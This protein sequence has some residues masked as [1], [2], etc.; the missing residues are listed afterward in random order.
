MTEE[1]ASG[2]EAAPQRI[3][4]VVESTSD[5]FTAQCYHLYRSPPLGAF[6][7]TDAPSNTASSAGQE[8]ESSHIYAVVCGVSTQALDPGRHV[9]ARGEDAD[10]EDEIYRSNP[11]LARLLC[12]RLE[13][14][15]VG[16]SDGGSAFNQYL[17]ALPPRIHAFVYPCIFEEVAHF[18]RSLDYLYLL[19]HSSR[20]GRGVADEVVAAC[21][22]QASAQLDDP[23]SFLVRA[24]KAL[25]V[26]L[27]DDLPRLNSI[28]RRLS[29]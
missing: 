16:H 29:P 4:E 5:R 14:L 8:G 3:G 18:T 27:T 28:L 11:Q 21:I 15:I 17:P 12:T 13:A 6:V 20:A 1:Q 10:S 24:G 2:H 7:R 19:V 22:R 26:V 9:I 25:A 23:L